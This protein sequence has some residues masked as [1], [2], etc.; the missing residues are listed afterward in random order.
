MSRTEE[1]ASVDNRGCVILEDTD[2][3][4]IADDNDDC[5]GTVS[6]TVV[7]KH[8]CKLEANID[9]DNVQFKLGTSVLSDDSRATLDDVAL[10]L[11]DNPHLEFIIAGHTDSMGN[12]DKNVALSKARANSVRQYLIGK[13]VTASHLTAEGYGPDKPVASND[14]AAGRSQNR[15][16]E[17]VLK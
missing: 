16:V 5:S 4:G 12:H 10:T 7:N 13:G 15:R 17:L 8:G 6:G 1:D 14:T 9:L 11:N 2:G 3:D